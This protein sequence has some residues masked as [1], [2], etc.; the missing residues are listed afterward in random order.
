MAEREWTIELSIIMYYFI[1]HIHFEGLYIHSIS[2]S[3]HQS[4]T[5]FKYYGH[6]LIKEE[7]LK[8]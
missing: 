2:K 7:E 3:I 4:K 6:F 5:L 8:Y 1:Y